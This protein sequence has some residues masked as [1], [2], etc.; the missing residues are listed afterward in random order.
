MA[1]RPVVVGQVRRSGVV[2]RLEAAY[3]FH[4]R[5]SKGVDVLIVV[6][7]GEEAYFVVLLGQGPAGQG[8]DQFVLVPVYVLV[9]I[10]EN[11]AESSEKPG[12][13][14]ICFLGRKA[15]LPA[16]GL[17]LPLGSAESRC[18]QHFWRGL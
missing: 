11:P 7:N 13:V 6:T 8:R 18:H 5:S 10:D 14:V 12:P 1:G 17:W 2:V 15:P 9:L 4:G 3:V 16:R